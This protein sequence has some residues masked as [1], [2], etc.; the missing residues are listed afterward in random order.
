MAAAFFQTAVGAATSAYG[1][2]P[3][4]GPARPAARPRFGCPPLHG[5]GDSRPEDPE[6]CRMLKFYLADRHPGIAVIDHLEPG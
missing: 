2:G 3:G 1:P 6:T 5:A 4:C